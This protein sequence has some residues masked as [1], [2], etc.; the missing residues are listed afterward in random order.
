MEQKVIFLDT[1]QATTKSLTS[2]KASWIMRQPVG[3]MPGAQ[4]ALSQLNFTN[5]FIN[6]SAAIGNNHFFYS[7]DPANETKYDI[8]IPDGSY[9]L[10]ALES[11]IHASILATHGFA[12]L[13]LNPNYSTNKVAITFD[14][15]VGWYVSFKV[16]SP[17]TLLG[18]TN[19]QFV[20]AG[21]SCTAYYTE[22]GPNNAAFN[23]IQTIKV[24]TN[25]TNDSISNTNQSPILYICQPIVSVGSTQTSE[26]RILMWIPSDAFRSK[27]YEINV[28]LMDQNDNP[29]NM[30][31]EF[32]LTLM[33][34]YATGEYGK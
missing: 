20:P 29:L 3:E 32:S 5:F 25:L 14:N 31:E 4:V 18:F 9:S 28:Q 12:I 26:A 16:N 7:D 2:G 22:Y 17:F 1:A 15:V 30:S 19:G 21:K 6:I 10:D 8:T 13:S 23:N 27:I 11:Y 33:V 34:K 24:A